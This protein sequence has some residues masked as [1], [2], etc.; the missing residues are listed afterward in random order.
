MI[1][2]HNLWCTSP[3]D[4]PYLDAAQSQTASRNPR[5]IDVSLDDQMERHRHQR[6]SEHHRCH[7]GDGQDSQ[8]CVPQRP[9]GGAEQHP[10]SQSSDP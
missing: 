7:H 9:A 5:R 6:Q 8:L 1:S 2:G 4:V 10:G 3:A